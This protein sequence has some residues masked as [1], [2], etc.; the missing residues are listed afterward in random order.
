L[1]PYGKKPLKKHVMRFALI[2]GT[3]LKK[4]KYNGNGTDWEKI[5]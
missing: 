1:F 5:Q 2:K 3:I 4:R